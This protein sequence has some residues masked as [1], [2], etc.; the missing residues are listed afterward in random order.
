MLKLPLSLFVMALSSL[1]FSWEDDDDEFLS[2]KTISY[3]G[4]SF[5][6][7]YGCGDPD[8]DS[9]AAMIQWLC[10]QWLLN[11][12]HPS[13]ELSIKKAPLIRDLQLSSWTGDR[14]CYPHLRDAFD[15][16]DM[17]NYESF[18]QT[19]SEFFEAL[20]DIRKTRLKNIKI[21]TQHLSQI[22]TLQAD[23]ARFIE[24]NGD[25]EDE[26]EGYRYQNCARFTVAAAINITEKSLNY[27]QKELQQ[28]ERYQRYVEATFAEVKSLYRAIFMN[29]LEKHQPEG[30]A[31]HSALEHFLTGDYYGAIEDINL[32]IS[33]AEKNSSKNTLIAKLYLLKGQVQSESC[34]YSDA[35]VALTEAIDKNPN[36]KEAFF[37][38]AVSYFELGDFDRSLE[39]YLSSNIRSGSTDITSILTRSF[40]LGLSK[41]VLTGGAQATKEFIPSMLASLQGIGHGLWA[42]AQD[43][44]EVSTDLV[45]AARNC[46]EFIKQNT[47]KKMIA[48]I[49]PEFAE[50]LESWHKIE[51]KEKGE[52]VGLL[53]GKYGVELFAGTG[54]V[55][56]MRLYRE[57]KQANHLLTFETM[58]IS[59]RNQEIIKA[60]A[61]EKAAARKIL[62]KTNLTIKPDAQGKHLI[63]H[64]NYE[65]WRNR[66]ITEHPDLQ[67]LVNKFA[68]TGIKKGPIRPGA[69]GY[70][71]TIDFKEFIGY[72]V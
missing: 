69:P 57:L 17:D 21:S 42:F 43:P 54:L 25:N 65:P 63:G 38:R 20:K 23:G 28:C 19:A 45:Q 58:A 18:L 32:L 3:Q 30:I 53:I 48:S 13:S 7:D 39:D 16:E 49:V 67:S 33:L 59:R 70:K 71:E 35:I 37:E 50:L 47:S 5:D 60:V 1:L 22:K 56:G 11:P 72:F 36:Q 10:R 40:A 41:G 66:S 4:L 27:N 26:I 52:M 9:N 29:C 2:S 44:I 62:L 55:K 6:C 34:L 64:K 12:I 51:E 15:W 46:V 31:F 24:F 61:A 8:F 14:L 68:G